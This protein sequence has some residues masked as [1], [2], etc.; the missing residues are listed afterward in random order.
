MSAIYVTNSSNSKISSNKDVDATYVTLCSCSNKC[1]LKN[2]GC[3]AQ[4]SYI[5]FIVTKLNNQSYY[6]DPISIAKI[7]A[8]VIDSS[9]NGKIIPNKA[10]R[11]HVSGDS[12]TIKGS[13][14]INDAVKRWKLRGGKVVWSYTHSW[15]NVERDIWNDVSMIASIDKI[16]QYKK[17]RDQGYS[18]AL[19]IKEHLNKK[20]HFINGSSIKWIPCLAQIQ[21]TT[22]IKCGLCLDEKTL[23]NK[24]LGILFA[25]HGINK[26]KIKFK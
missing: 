8:S 19:I 18:S 1:P 9:Y 7:E 6:L 11:L 3:Y 26:N 4:N 20:P 14:I 24:N 25:A 5:N 21:D 23:F 15:R 12:K 17:A 2:K 10:L 16:E 22:C 13:K